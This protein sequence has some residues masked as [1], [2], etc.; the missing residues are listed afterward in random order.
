MADN[1]NAGAEAAASQSSTK[2]K[3][4]KKTKKKTA[5][6]KKSASK[7]IVAKKG[8]TKKATKKKSSGAALP[9]PAS[10]PAAA[11]PSDTGPV[12]DDDQGDRGVLGLVVQWGPVVLLLLL[13]WVLDSRSD[14]GS[15]ASIE[16]GDEAATL[17]PTS[18]DTD[19]SNI[20]DTD[21]SNIGA[22]ELPSIDPWAFGTNDAELGLGDLELGTDAPWLDDPAAFYWGPALPEDFPPAP[23][24]NQQ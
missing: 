12:W 10:I 6:K 4:A 20:G 3:A 23:S 1:G 19:L 15:E 16:L 11:M 22:I 24:A 21:L 13:I 5:T 17:Q 2:K 8:A 18:T 14:E 7:K 9:E